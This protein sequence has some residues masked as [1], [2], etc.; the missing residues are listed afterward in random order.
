MAASFARQAPRSVLPYSLS[1]TSPQA[2][3]LH[4]LIMERLAKDRR[5]KIINNRYQI[6]ARDGEVIEARELT[7]AAALGELLDK[8][9]NVR[10]PASVDEV[11][12]RVSNPPA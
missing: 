10:M 8:V 4:V 12:A 6:E 5:Y 7:S 1:T 9:F 11:F 3:F 2:P